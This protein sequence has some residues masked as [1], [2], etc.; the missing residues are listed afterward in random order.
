[1]SILQ[2]F[3]QKAQQAAEEHGGKVQEGLAKVAEKIDEKTGGRYHEKIQSA[4]DKAEGY[5]DSL[6]QQDDSPEK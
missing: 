1:M 5:L 2:K 4:T 3:R 6:K